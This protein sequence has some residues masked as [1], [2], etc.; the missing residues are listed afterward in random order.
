MDKKAVRLTAALAVLPQG[1][2]DR[3]ALLPGVDEEQALF[4]PR[5][6]KNISQPR[7][8]VVR[9][10]VGFFLQHRQGLDIRPVPGGLDILHIEM[11]HAQPPFDALGLDPGDDRLPPG[12]QGE[13]L[14]RP[15][16]V[17]HGG[18]Q[19]DAPGVDPRQTAQTLNKAQGLSAPVP[20]QEGVNLV[21]DHEPQITEELGDS[22]VLVEQHGLQ[23]LR[24][25]L[26]NAGG[27]LHEPFLVALGH[28]A[29]PVPDGNVCL[30]AQVVEPE[31]LVVDEGLQG[32]D[33]D[34]AHGGRWVLRKEGNN[35]EE[36]RLRLAGGGRGGEE[37]VIVRAEDHLRRSHLDGPEA[38]PAVAVD[39]LLHKGGVVVEDVH[40]KLLIG[41][42]DTLEFI[43]P[44]EL[45]RPYSDPC[46]T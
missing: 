4:A 24:G 16:R 11:L 9:S 20:P 1:G 27:A 15:L 21:D 8:R 45:Q 23:G 22:G 31:E 12:A 2:G 36:G 44:A 5:V 32:A 28:V 33:V 30:L 14:P 26:Q 35:G 40:G 39:V 10:L 3:L 38:L 34:A 42:F 46:H 18:G 19:A 17:A 25:D 41:S 6:F 13:E 7:V 37:Q 43:K 29:V